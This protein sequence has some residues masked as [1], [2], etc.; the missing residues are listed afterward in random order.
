MPKPLASTLI[1]RRR[2]HCA[3]N[4]S[5]LCCPGA[6]G[7]AFILPIPRRCVA[8]WPGVCKSFHLDT[9][10]ATT[11]NRPSGGVIMPLENRRRAATCIFS[12][13]SFLLLLC[14][15]GFGQAN[16]QL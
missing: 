13:L 5:I 15:L 10:A 2:V 3:L 6:P 8:S 14:G 7:L 11:H 1:T 9:P 16:V 12:I 4:H